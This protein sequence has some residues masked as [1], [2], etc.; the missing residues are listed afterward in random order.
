VS[1]TASLSATLLPLVGVLIGVGITWAKDALAQRKTQSRNAHYLALRV[2]CL[3]DRYIED[4]AKVADDDGSSPNQQDEEGASHPMTDLPPAP[5]FPADVDW[6][7]IDQRTAYRLVSID[8]ETIRANWI[9]SG[10]EDNAFPPD[11]AEAFEERRY[12]YAR[13]GLSALAIAHELRAKYRIPEPEYGYWVPA[14]R[15][16]STKDEIETCRK[17]RADA[18]SDLL[19]PPVPVQ[20][21]AG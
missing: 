9:I 5:A 14:E 10:A 13:L 17:K 6:K 4:C 2:V 12:Q 7:S 16:T 8:N 11:Y 20:Q 1:S 21:A 18:L 15:L 3:L 19:P